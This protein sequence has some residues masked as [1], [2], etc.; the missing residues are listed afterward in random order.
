MKKFLFL[1]V[2]FVSLIFLGTFSVVSAQTGTDFNS[3]KSNTSVVAKLPNAG[4]TPSSALYFL[5]RW[6][7]AIQELLARS[8]KA[9]ARLQVAFAGERI[10]EIKLM[11]EAKDVK[12]EGLALAE[13]R[14]REHAKK[15]RAVVDEEKVKGNE[16]SALANEIVE[17]FHTQRVAALNEFRAAKEQF[18]VQK[19]ELLD[20]LRA[21]REARNEEEVA[22]IR[23]ELEHIETIKDLA[24]EQKDFAIDALEEEKEWLLDELDEEAERAHKRRER[25]LEERERMLEAEEEALERAVEEQ[26]RAMEA[27]ERASDRAAEQAQEALERAREKVEQTQKRLE[28][29]IEREEEKAEKQRKEAEDKRTE[30]IKE[31]EEQ[32]KSDKGEGAASAQADDAEE[33]SGVKQAE[34]VEN[35]QDTPIVRYTATGFSPR[36]ITIEKGEIVTFINESTSGMWVASA[37]HPTHTVYPEKT[38]NDCLGSAFDACEALSSGESWSFTFNKEGTWVYH[39]H[40]RANHTGTITVE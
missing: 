37:V 1:S 22:R 27:L 21:A 12:P 39:N 3:S 23:A 14:I 25:E 5:D 24:D 34:E 10:A 15:A 18:L 33:S 7:E 31:M 32:E 30:D 26:E 8:P 29:K 20:E 2:I 17:D 19:K 16:T 36:E 38:G 40:T 13:E 11:L 4:F 6:G 9:K 28:E 35:S